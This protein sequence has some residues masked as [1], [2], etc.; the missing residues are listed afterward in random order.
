M[1][2]QVMKGA[3]SWGASATVGDNG[4]VSGSGEGDKDR[5]KNSI[6]GRGAQRCA[7]S[8]PPFM[9]SDTAN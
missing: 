3:G 4:G 9:N 5:M 6:P 2:S 8:C 1:L 7:T